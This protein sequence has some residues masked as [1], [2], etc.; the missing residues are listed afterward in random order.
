MLCAAPSNQT[1][2]AQLG[3]SSQVPS[4]HDC[5][6]S[7]P[8][9]PQHTLTTKYPALVHHHFAEDIIL[10]PPRGTLHTPECLCIATH[11]TGASPVSVSCTCC[12]C[13]I[14]QRRAAPLAI[15]RLIVYYFNTEP[16]SPHPRASPHP[17]PPASVS[18]CFCGGC[19][20]CGGC[21]VH[22]HVPHQPVVVPWFLQTLLLPLQE[23]SRHSQPQK[24]QHSCIHYPGCAW[25]PRF[26]Q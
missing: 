26:L 4:C 18:E 21:G 22:R 24:A 10:E 20:G 3:I 8:L 23:P 19:G 17:A 16:P 14:A 13:L 6:D 5:C 15:L 2:N 7:T 12:L 9:T 1:P 25:D 11:R